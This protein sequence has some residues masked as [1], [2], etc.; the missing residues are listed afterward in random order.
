V[1]AAGNVGT[2]SVSVTVSND[3]T[4][5][6]VSVTSP[7]GGATVSGLVTI[8]ATASDDVGVVGVQFQ[9][10]GVNVGAEDTVAPYSVA[11]DAT[12]AAVGTHTITAVARDA[13]GK[14]ST[15][16]EVAVTVPDTTPPAVS[17]T[18]P[19]TG[20]TVAGLVT[21]SA[22]A[23]DNLGI[24][25]VQFKL[26]GVDLGVEDTV[27]PY[28]VSWDTTTAV[29]GSHTLTAV[30]RD[31]AGNLATSAPVVVTVKRQPRPDNN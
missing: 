2:A 21:V 12:T 22:S 9:V 31:A 4:P 6:A 13:A 24:V 25:G 3:I 16:A 23:A 1:D 8:V 5:P 17:V 29:N 30:A 26:D 19:V 14:L 15:S 20:A 28:A 11:W 7:L 27:A 10:D 18:S